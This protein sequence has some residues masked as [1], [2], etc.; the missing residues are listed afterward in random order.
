MCR[1]M[2]MKTGKLF[3]SFQEIPAFPMVLFSQVVG[4]LSIGFPHRSIFNYSKLGYENPVIL[5]AKKILLHPRSTNSLAFQ[6][7]KWHS[8]E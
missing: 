5:S 1:R 2:S 6:I 4:N 8:L 7:T 3:P